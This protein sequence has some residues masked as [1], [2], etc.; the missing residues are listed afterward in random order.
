[1]LCMVWNLLATLCR[2]S[3]LCNP[4]HRQNKA[5]MTGTARNRSLLQVIVYVSM[6]MHVH[7]SNLCFKCNTNICISTCHSAAEQPCMPTPMQHCPMHTPCLASS[8]LVGVSVYRH[9]RTLDSLV[10]YLIARIPASQEPSPWI[11]WYYRSVVPNVHYAAFNDEKDIIKVR[12]LDGTQVAKAVKHCI[13][14]HLPHHEQPPPATEALTAC[15]VV[16]HPHALDR[17]LTV[18]GPHPTTQA[19]SKLI[20][21][22]WTAS[23]QTHPPSLKLGWPYKTLITYA[24][25]INP[26]LCTSHPQVIQALEADPQRRRAIADAG[27]RFAYKYIR[28]HGKTLYTAGVFRAFNEL[29]SHGDLADFLGTLDGKNLPL[30]VG[31]LLN[32]MKHFLDGRKQEQ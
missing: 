28:N 3:C 31:D 17:D 32:L 6:Y 20:H 16:L 14:A 29:F 26:S 18:Y 22:P 11:E 21:L 10:T 25:R 9:T 12:A 27:Q 19:T 8:E 2:G 4:H 5:M 13:L 24:C 15:H 23:S 30:N 7:M 1:M